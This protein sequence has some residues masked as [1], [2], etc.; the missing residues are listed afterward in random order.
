M[1]LSPSRTSPTLSVQYSI[2]ITQIKFCT[3]WKR[4]A[5][6]HLGQDEVLT[7]AGL[8]QINTDVQWTAV[9]SLWSHVSAGA[10]TWLR[11]FASRLHL[12]TVTTTRHPHRLST[13]LHFNSI[14]IPYAPLN[15]AISAFIS[16]TPPTAARRIKQDKGVFWWIDNNL[17]SSRLIMIKHNPT[18]PHNVRN[19][20]TDPRL[21]F[22]F[23]L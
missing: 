23:K 9:T 5:S 11:S 1:I 3:Q 8:G 12:V 19:N 7:T 15:H 18:R 16:N 13:D 4:R 21:R 22:Q 14:Q 17:L 2:T 20:F 6:Q 10:S